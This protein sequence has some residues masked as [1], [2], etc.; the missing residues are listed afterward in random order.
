MAPTLLGLSISL[1]LI[2]F[3]KSL[4]LCLMHRV[5]AF[6]LTVRRV[7][8][9]HF[10][11]FVRVG[12]GSTK[13]IAHAVA[14]ESPT[15]KVYD[16]LPPP[17]EELDDVLAIMFTRP[18]EPVKYPEDSPP[19]SI[20]YKSMASNKPPKATSV[21]DTEEEDGVQDGWCPFIMH[22][23]FG[24]D[25]VTQTS[26]ELFPYGLGGIGS[27]SVSLSSAQHKR[28]LLMYHDKR[29]QT[30]P[31]F[32]FVKASTTGSFLLAEKEKFFDITNHILDVD[33]SVLTELS[34]CM[35]KGD[36]VCP[37]SDKEKD[38]FQ[39]IRDLDHVGGKVQGSIT[40]KKCSFM[41]DGKETFSPDLQS[42]DACVDLIANNPVAGARFFNFMVDLFI[43]HVLGVGTDHPGAFG[44]TSSYY[45]TVEQQG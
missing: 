5:V 40:S 29:F 24:Q 25:I 45:D 16:F 36:V 23:L 30:D 19:V 41:A 38:C 18:R 33:Q 12:S 11:C 9:M 31:T 39:L 43:K 32:P 28:R 14:F 27:T 42:K 20:Q 22:G 3:R 37:E 26:E 35:S 21:F 17:V 1:S 8:A 2:Q 44:Q 7:Y 13:M 15:P 4:G 34:K 6:A 10:N